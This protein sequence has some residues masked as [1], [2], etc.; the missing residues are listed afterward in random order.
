MLRLRTD[1]LLVIF[2]LSGCHDPDR[3]LSGKWFTSELANSESGASA[4]EVA[5]ILGC[6]TDDCELFVE[7]NLGHY[8]EDVVGVIRFYRDQNRVSPTTCDVEGC[9]C[10]SIRGVYREDGMFRFN[11][12]DCGGCL[13]TAEVEW[14]TDDRIVWQLSSDDRLNH[15]DSDCVPYTTE[16]DKLTIELPLS[17]LGNESQLTV[18]DKACDECGR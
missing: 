5:Q 17:K 7:M 11:F 8:G 16:L 6:Q 3:F 18:A 12:V 2:A 9:G 10:R 14:E 13:R 4:S 1:L 15:T